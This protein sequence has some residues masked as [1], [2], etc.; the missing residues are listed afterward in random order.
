MKEAADIS[1]KKGGKKKP[2]I[3]KKGKEHDLPLKIS[4]PEV[5]LVEEAQWTNYD[6]PY[7]K[8]TALRIRQAPSQ[9]EVAENG[10][11]TYDFFV[12][13]DNVHLLRELKVTKESVELVKK[14]F[15]LG[16]TLL[17]LG[18]L[19]ADMENEEA[20]N[21][22]LSSPENSEPNIEDKVE[23]FT[24]AVAPILLPMI[25]CLGDLQEDDLSVATEAAGEAV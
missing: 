25:S 9:N 23:L 18:L 22:D 1:G 7:D 15:E 19:Q 14:R 4:L 13:I 16:L 11:P 6:P 10:Q 2:P 12:N 5:T 24:K 3:E 17:G 21:G 20:A 8:F